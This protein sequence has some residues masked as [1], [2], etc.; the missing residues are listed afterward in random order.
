MGTPETSFGGREMNSFAPIDPK[1]I[2]TPSPEIAMSLDGMSGYVNDGGNSRDVL[3]DCCGAAA[4]R[5]FPQALWIEPRDWADKARDNDV[6]KTW[7]MNY[8]DRY[9]NQNPTHECTCH[10]LRANAEAARNRQRGII[11]EDGPKKNYRYAESVNG[12]VWLSPLSVYA[13]ANPGQW[14][15]A[16]VRQVLE[17]ACERGFLPEKIQPKEYG[18]K[19]VLQGT[20]GDGNN[21]QS[22]GSWVRVSNF[23]SGW[24]ETAKLFKPE[25]VIFPESYEQAV[26][27]VLHGML[28]SVG[29]NGHAVPWAQWNATEQAMAYPDSYDITRYDSLRTVK[30]SWDGAFAIATMT[31]PDDWDKPAG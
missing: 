16:N 12:S 25:E 20:T 2:D 10:S 29:R 24:Q 22:S 15:G 9:T 21:N 27:L 18:F 6:N 28:V 3:K 7:G 4:V 5:D 17:I 31:T 30:N 26:C 23:P 8:L 14:G 1:L 13:E 11:F 19:H